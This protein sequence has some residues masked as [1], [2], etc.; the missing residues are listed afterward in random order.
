MTFKK[1]MKLIEG[2]ISDTP[3]K[4]YINREINIKSIEKILYVYDLK[5]PESEKRKDKNLI[6]KFLMNLPNRSYQKYIDIEEVEDYDFSNNLILEILIRNRV[7]K[8]F[9]RPY[10]KYKDL[11]NKT[12]LTKVEKSIERKYCKLKRGY[13]EYLGFNMDYYDVL[14]CTFRGIDTNNFSNNEY[15]VDSF[16]RICDIKDGLKRAIQYYYEK[17]S[18]CN[19]A[20]QKNDIL[21]TD[22]I[23]YYS[24]YRF[25]TRKKIIE[26]HEE[27]PISVLDDDFLSKLS[28][29]D[30][31]NRIERIKIGSIF[32]DLEFIGAKIVT[33]DLNMNLPLEELVAYITKIK[34]EYSKNK[35]P[36]EI[37]NIEIEKIDNPKSLEL[38]PKDKKKRNKAYADAF[39]IYDSFYCI[40][41]YF[42]KIR[43]DMKNEY[44]EEK[45]K[46][47]KDKRINND[48]KKEK[49]STLTSEYKLELKKYSHEIIYD[50]IEEITEIEINKVKKLHKLLKE[51]IEDLK[52]KNILLINNN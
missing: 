35:S 29:N 10:L 25:I 39:H 28:P 11:A 17:D 45:E 37:L 9:L 47:R 20:L 21:L 6:G 12:E 34:K 3:T 31:I 26:I 8:N 44:E 22:V 27:L 16:P 41:N 13:S 7:F 43:K 49:I 18:I 51:Y 52:Y 1:I 38:I 4:G 19:Y 50:I 5:V 36:L 15:N 32:T 23:E 2:T 46:L 48:L 24:D 42:Y 40:Y 30:L 14:K 33:I